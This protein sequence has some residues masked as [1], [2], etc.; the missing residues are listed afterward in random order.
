M[1]VLLTLIL[2]FVSFSAH[3]QKMSVAS[4]NIRCI[5]NGDTQKGN[6]WEVRCPAVANLVRFHDFDI[7]GAQEV[8]MR[9]Q[10]DDLLAVLPEY[11]YIGVGRDDG[12]D[13]GEASPIFYKKSRFELLKEGH[14]W[15]S[16]QPAEPSK[17]WDAA[18]PRICSWGVFKD[19]ESAKTFWFF[20]LHFDHVGVVARAESAKLV[21]AKIREMCGDQPAILTGDFNVDQHNPS[22]KLIAESG[23]LHCAYETCAVRYAPN[24]SFNS[25]NL[26]GVT[27]SR[28]D[29]IFTTKDFKVERYGILTD[30]YCPEKGPPRLPSDHF[31]IKVIVSY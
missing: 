17:G 5:N 25:F 12:K 22:Y 13:R 3:A 2:L 30:T 6:G 16:E 19:K 31:P 11:H 7:W 10:L 9:K 8:V 14:F 21:L 18:L 28:I 27:D 15:L 20:N 1:K 26:Q 24:G 4:Y 23:L 29:H